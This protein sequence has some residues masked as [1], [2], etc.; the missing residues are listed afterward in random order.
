MRRPA[1]SAWYR[2]LM[3][4]RSYKAPAVS[5]SRLFRGASRSAS[6]PKVSKL[7]PMNQ[8]RATRSTR[9]ATSP[10]ISKNQASYRSRG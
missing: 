1:P 4:A 6:V 2:R 10:N 7:N 5:S 8:A 3:A 9:S